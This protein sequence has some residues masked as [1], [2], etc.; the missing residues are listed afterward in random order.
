MLCEK[1]N[2]KKANTTKQV[3]ALIWKDFDLAETMIKHHQQLCDVLQTSKIM[4]F[5]GS[6]TSRNDHSMM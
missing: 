3:W 1:E 5:S 4:S 2:S 6:D